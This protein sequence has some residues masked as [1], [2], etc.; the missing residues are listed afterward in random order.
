MKN[1]GSPTSTTLKDGRDFWNLEK[2]HRRENLRCWKRK[3]VNSII[4]ENVKSKQNN[5]KTNHPNQQKH[6]S[7]HKTSGSI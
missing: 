7:S 3:K 1:S 2:G 5:K 6:K 4:K